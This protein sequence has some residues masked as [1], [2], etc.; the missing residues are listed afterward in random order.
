MKIYFNLFIVCI[1]I[2]MT[3]TNVG[4]QCTVGIL[5]DSIVV[6]CGDSVD[7][8]A[9]GFLGDSAQTT[10]FNTGV[11]G[12]G[13]TSTTTLLYTD[14]C[15][16][17]LDGTPSAWFG[18]VPLPRTLTTNSFDMSCG[19]QICFDLDFAGDEAGN[20][21]SCE[22]PDEADEGVFFQY[23]VDAGLNWTTIN[24]F[25]PIPL[26]TSGTNPIYGWANYCF[27]LPAA[28]WTTNTIFRWD[29]P[30]A[31]ASTND[32]WGIDNVVISPSG[33]SYWYDWSNIPGT[34]NGNSQTVSP[35]TSI[36]YEV[37]YTDGIDVCNDSVTVVVNNLVIDVIA[38]DTLICPGV[39]IDLD[40]ILL[41]APANICSETETASGGDD[42][43]SIKWTTFPCVPAGVAVTGIT[44]DAS[45]SG[46]CD[47]WSAY[48]VIVNGTTIAFAQ[49]DTIGL[50]LTS[51]LPI[52]SITI[53][54]IDMDFFSDNIV[55][56]ATINISYSEYYSY[57]YLWTPSAGLNSANIQNP[58][59][60]PSSTII[61]GAM[62]T[63]TISG[64]TAKDSITID[65]DLNAV[66]SLAGPI[67]GTAI[68]C[69]NATGVAYSVN[70]VFGA[71]GYTWTLPIGAI[72][73]SGSGTDSITVDF[74]T[75]SGIVGVAAINS[76]GSGAEDSITVIV[77]SIDTS[78]SLIGMSISSNENGAI[79]QWIDCDNDSINGETNQSYTPAVNGNY[80]VLISVNGCTDTS[81]CYNYLSTEV[82]NTSVKSERINIY[83]NP[84]SGKV[85]INFWGYKITEASI[86]IIDLLG[87]TV[88]Q[89]EI[90]SK[91]SVIDISR[92]SQGIYF[93]NFKN[94]EGSTVH[95]IIKK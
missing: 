55:L 34:N 59:A 49:C 75:N 69:E 40:V 54:S 60:C 31:T 61:Y 73:T 44:L 47:A 48:D 11:I 32:H 46:L 30:D 76:C 71:T 35:M 21:S 17:S 5:P 86:E 3:S 36:S 79:Y 26:Y 10:N 80:A 23:S 89:E 58:N 56:D 94:E 64:C 53:Q 39:C 29:Q 52:D 66:P 20:L 45:T 95:K 65:V 70:P 85:L 6:T 8:S 15:G 19:G 16:P 33:C 7:I 57:N 22:D 82:N 14:P 41:N 12:V 43:T 38:T 84:T 4:A 42:V 1:T 74:G 37:T 25:N 68:V 28:A 50:D 87:K 83:P 78:V 62:L 77:N 67:T 92:F 90:K 9:L 24:Y 88:Y 27:T 91:E 72:I 51:Y 63:D 81:A 2:L 93:L 13:W 18:N